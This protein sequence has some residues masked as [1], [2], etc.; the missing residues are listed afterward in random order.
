MS[1][2]QIAKILEKR[3][4]EYIHYYSH[5]LHMD[6]IYVHHYQP[7]RY[8]R[9]VRPTRY[10]Q[11]IKQIRQAQQT[12]RVK[13]NQRQSNVLRFHIYNRKSQQLYRNRRQ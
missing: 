9:Q 3:Y 11:S 13:L 12:S 6:N 4:P 2:D 1:Q 10:I 8:I 7:V 5:G